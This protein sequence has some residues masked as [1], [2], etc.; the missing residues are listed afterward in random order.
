MDINSSRAKPGYY[1]IEIYFL[2]E[3]KVMG[4]AIQYL[5]VFLCNL[6]ERYCENGT[7]FICTDDGME[8]DRVLC[9]YGCSEDKKSCK[10]LV[11]ICEPNSKWCRN[12]TLFIC[13]ELGTSISKR[14]CVHG[15]DE[16]GTACALKKSEGK[17]VHLFLIIVI[18]LVMLYLIYTG[19]LRVLIRKVRL[20]KEMKLIDAKMKERV[21]KYIKEGRHDKLY[22]IYASVMEFYDKLIEREGIEAERRLEDIKLALKAMLIIEAVKKARERGIKAKYDSMLALAERYAEMISDKDIKTILKKM[23]GIQK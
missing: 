8:Y 20:S 21:I 7:L 15:C 16:N 6:G 12:D 3:G 22:D 18:V 11:I 13:N 23:V 10:E 4:R 1:K 14:F 2:S 5:T 9:S 19:Y 17:P